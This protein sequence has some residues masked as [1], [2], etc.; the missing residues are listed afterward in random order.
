MSLESA[1]FTVKSCIASTLQALLYKL[2]HVLPTN[3]Y[4]VRKL[5]MEIRVI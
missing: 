1:K 3:V 4:V 5:R 2:Y